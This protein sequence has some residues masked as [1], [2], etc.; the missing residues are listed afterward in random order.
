MI[1]HPQRNGPDALRLHAPQDRVWRW[2]AAKA[3]KNLV[4]CLLCCL[5][6]CAARG[7]GTELSFVDF[8]SQGPFNNFSGDS[9][10][11]AS[12]GAS[13]ATAFDNQ[14]F[15]GPNGASL[16]LDYAVP[17]G[18]CGVWYSLLGKASFPKYT[19][20]FTNLYGPLKN[21]A[22]NPSRV[23]QVRVKTFSFWAR[24][25]GNGEFD[26]E[27]KVEFKDPDRVLGSAV[28]AVPNGT[29]WVR[30]DFPISQLGSADLSRM[31]E[32]VFVI[33]DWRNNNR[34][35]HLYLDD[36]SFTTD[37]PACNPE[38]W[39][40]DAMLDLVAQRAF[41]YFLTF[42]DDSAFALDRSTYSDMVSVGTIG[43]QL[44]AYCIG[45]RR[46]WADRADLESRVV[47]ILQNLHDLPMG[48][49]EGT[50]RAG[51]RGFYYHFLKANSGRRMDDHVEL[52]LYDTMLLMYGVLSCR[53]YF[54][55]NPR[56]QTLSQQLYDR[57][58]WDWFVDH[59]PGIN[60]NRF[61]LA[62]QPGPNR[63]GTFLKHVD[64]QTD[65]AFMVDVLAMGSRTHPTSL[66]TYI[67]RNRVYGSYPPANP[68]SIM[69]SW[70]GSLFNYFFASCW[71]NFKD[72]GLDLHP[73]GPRDL[74][75]NDK[76]AILANR[77]FCLDHA[78]RRSGGLD[79]HYLTYG[80]SAWGLTACDNL[81]P[82]VSG[83]PSEYFSFGALPTE[84]NIRFGTKPPQ[85]G[86]LAVYGAVSSINFVPQTALA[87]LRHYFQIPA[88]WSPLFGFGDAFSLDPHYLGSPYDTEGNPTVR[89][90]DYLNG[91]WINHMVMGI[92]VGPMLLAI[93]NYRSRLLWELTAEN[94]EIKSGLDAIFGACSPHVVKVSVDPSAT[95]ARVNLRWE[96]GHGASHYNI[97]SSTDLQ[98]WTLLKRDIR[99]TDWTDTE[100][101]AGSQR[102][103]QV[104]GLP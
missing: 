17:A 78:G 48:P 46:G 94:P 12:K 35:G 88:L 79:D 57:V 37:E 27:I 82:P 45:H 72:R 23:E 92:N 86:T 20:N 56:I 103:Y 25:D 16:R 70:R 3:V 98:N 96:S 5:L 76:L 55:A 38:L 90:A 31:K 59:T 22:G 58:E 99:G 39:S 28:F 2:D 102:F 97:Y 69:V 81:V 89:F 91:P 54:S 71:L 13:L 52:S 34:T 14:I 36:L 101:A 30:F 65:E 9:G 104:K 33:E 10:N 8:N 18:F 19:L 74:W 11:F 75:E 41:F 26:H 32:V 43:F 15:R 24:G 83:L 87:A 61:Y 51:Y 44:T 84:E 49:E 29:N 53:E 95:Y 77:R 1:S 67:A 63:Q 62:W 42:T 21:S 68:Q 64:G 85:A 6:P 4:L 80:D 66:E 60:S 47:T 40:D 100:L 50:S 7:E 73:S 93:E